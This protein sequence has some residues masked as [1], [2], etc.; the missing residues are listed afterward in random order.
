VIVVLAVA[1]AM[2]ASSACGSDRRAPS[3]SALRD[4]AITVAS[5]N[6]PE[7][8]LIARI[9]GQAMQA[10]GYHVRYALNLGPREFVEPALARGLVEFVPEYAGTALLFLT[11]N[12]TAPSS[13]ASINHSRLVHALRNSNIAPLSAAPAQD[14]N[15]F[16][17]TLDTAA[18]YDLHNISDLRKISSKLTFGGPPECPTRPTCGLGLR[19]TYG[20]NIKR[21]LSTDAGGPLTLQALDTGLVDVALLFSTDPRLATGE[22]LEL[23]DDR[24]LQ[25]AESV[26]PLVRREVLRRWGPKLTRLVD[27]VSARLTTDSL[28][29]LN[30]EILVAK[31]PP[32]DVAAEWL[33]NEG[34]R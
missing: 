26:T 8:A 34:L 3:A 22:L 16:V 17:V 23:R 12:K 24:R 21:Y 5:F 25:P 32:A 10:G 18:R 30:R 4:D 19:Q 28:R 33:K 31:R 6:F 13:N 1:G 14:A 9:Y 7:S 15:D 27:G 20:L 11:Q 2:L 29:E